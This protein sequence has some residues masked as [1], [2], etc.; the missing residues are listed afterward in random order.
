MDPTI[1]G[2]LIGFVGTIIAAF[3]T[4]GFVVVRVSNP[5][6]KIGAFTSTLLSF[7]SKFSITNARIY[8]IKEK[9]AIVDDI[10]QLA[11]GNIYT[12]STSI[13]LNI[14]VPD[15]ETYTYFG[16]KPGWSFH[17]KYDYDKY[18]LT[19]LS[20]KD[21]KYCTVEIRKIGSERLN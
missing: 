7:Y 15:H 4:R 12:S 13:D 11:V 20:V 6:R 9:S 3:I 18:R 14:T 1:L 21:Y 16:I 10:T 8:T 17:F 5:S 2:A 19:V